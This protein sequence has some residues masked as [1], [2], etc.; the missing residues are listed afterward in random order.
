MNPNDEELDNTSLGIMP[1]P[2]KLVRALMR[3]NQSFV[4]INFLSYKQQATGDFA[5]LTGEEAYEVYAKSVEKVQ[6]PLASRLLWAGQVH[7]DIAEDKLLPF[8]TIA[9]LEYASPKAFMQANF[10]GK[11]NTKARIAGL[12]GQ[13][14]FASTTLTTGVFPDPDEEH[15]VLIELMGGIKRNSE[16]VKRWHEVQQSTYQSVGAKTIW[17]GRCDHH[18]LGNAIPE[19]EDLMVTW[20]PNPGS[21]EEVMHDPQRN[22]HLQNIR[23]YLTYKASSIDL[24]PELR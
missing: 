1:N 9:L 21:L 16:R 7:Q 6:G 14:L 17:H 2:L 22:Q 3:P 4:M 20:F 11:S 12:K 8:E 5:H 19:I 15:V 10:K 23:P 13:W 24:L 18:I